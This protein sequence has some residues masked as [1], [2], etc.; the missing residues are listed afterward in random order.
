MVALENA[1]GSDG[2]ER[3]KRLD[4]TA[5]LPLSLTALYGKNQIE[6]LSGLAAS[7]P[8][9]SRH[10]QAPHRQ[11]LLPPT[12]CSTAISPAS[13]SPPGACPGRG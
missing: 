8:E 10:L 13:W 11:V 12:A 4:G 7:E 1:L 2:K 6:A 3:P 5:Q 9:V